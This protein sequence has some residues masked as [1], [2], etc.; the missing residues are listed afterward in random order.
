MTEPLP[1]AVT[2]EQQA[3]HELCY[4]TLAHGDPSFI[5]Q[6]VVDAFA[7]Q[8]ANECDKP[9]KLTF[10]LVGLYFHVEKNYSGKQ[11]QRMHMQLGRQKRPWPVFALPAHRGSINATHV[12]AVP[13]G[14]DRDRMIHQWCACI[15]E[16]FHESRQM[17][18][19]LLAQHV[20]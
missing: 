5:H 6:H 12:L 20:K 16:A 1:P 18:V 15:W 3:Y 14:A 8:S 11:V 17:V 13:A 4:Y 7:A 10:A 19:D 9:I 2:S